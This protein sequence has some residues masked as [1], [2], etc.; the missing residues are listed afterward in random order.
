MLAA[1]RAETA[2]LVVAEDRPP[3]GA[4]VR[5]VGIWS[6]SRAT[7]SARDVAP[8]AARRTRSGASGPIRRASSASRPSGPPRRAPLADRGPGAPAAGMAHE[9]DLRGPR[10]RQTGRA[11]RI[12]PRPAAASRKASR[13]GPGLDV[14][15]ELREQRLERMP[16][17]ARPG[18]PARAPSGR[19]LREVPLDRAH[20]GGSK[21]QRR[22]RDR[23]S[24]R[25]RRGAWPSIAARAR[26]GRLGCD[27]RSAAGRGRGRGR[28]RPD[29]ARRGPSPSSCAARGRS[30]RRARARTSRGSGSGENRCI[31][32]TCAPE[33]PLY[34]VWPVT[35][36]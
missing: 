1:R 28:A 26:L 5:L 11:S 14:V 2:G 35:R 31:D 3:E 17:N 6:S 23:R 9:L 24:R 20:H 30:R 21:R 13:A 32:I 36:W 8:R 7:R 10:A 34:G 12:G 16:S 15:A 4:A 29:S 33:V 18:A 25:R 27:A 22:S 19:P